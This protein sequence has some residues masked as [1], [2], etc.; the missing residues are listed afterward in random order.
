L[1]IALGFGAVNVLG[2][3]EFIS[4]AFMA[5]FVVL[6]GVLPNLVLSFFELPVSNLSKLF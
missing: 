3:I 2:K 1:G 4:L 6:L 5:F